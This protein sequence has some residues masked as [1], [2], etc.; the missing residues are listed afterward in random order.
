MYIIATMFFGADIKTQPQSNN[1]WV[2]DG[3]GFS[4]LDSSTDTWLPSANPIPM[5]QI[6]PNDAPFLF[7]FSD[8]DFSKDGKHLYSTMIGSN[9]MINLN[10][11]TRQTDS[12][13]PF[14]ALSEDALFLPLNVTTSKTTGKL[15]A[16]GIKASRVTLPSPEPSASSTPQ[17]SELAGAFESAKFNYGII[18]M[19]PVPTSFADE[20]EQADYLA[21]IQ[22]IYTDID[23]ADLSNAFGDSAEELNP[24]F[25]LLSILGTG[26]PSLSYDDQHLIMPYLNLQLQPFMGQQNL[27]L[28][29]G[30]YEYRMLNLQSRTVDRT[31][32]LSDPDMFLPYIMLFMSSFGLGNNR[33]GDYVGY[34]PSKSS[35]HS[36]IAN[37]PGPVVTV[38][39]E[40]RDPS[41]SPIV[42]TP[43]PFSPSPDSSTEPTGAPTGSGSA[44]SSS[45]PGGVV[46]EQGSV[47]DIISKANSFMGQVG[48]SIISGVKLIPAPAALGFPWLLLFLLFVLAARLVWQARRE[49]QANRRLR[50]LLTRRQQI[51]EDE[52]NFISLASH[53]LNTPITIIQ[54]AIDVLYTTKKI[55]QSTAKKLQDMTKRIADKA[56]LISSNLSGGRADTAG[57]IT[58]EDMPKSIVMRPAVIVAISLVVAL[59]IISNWLFIGAGTLQ[60]SAINIITQL[61]ALGILVQF[62]VSSQRYRQHSAQDLALVQAQLKQIERLEKTRDEFLHETVGE[63]NTDVETLRKYLSATGGLSNKQVKDGVARLQ[64]LLARL[65]LLSTIERSAKKLQKSTFSLGG[66]AGD[67]KTTYAKGLKAKGI[68]LELQGLEGFS[69]RQ[70]REMLDLVLTALVDNA[71]KFAPEKTGR[72]VVSAQRKGEEVLIRVSDN[73]PGIAEAKRDSLFKP[74]SRTQSALKF[75]YEGQGLSLYLAKLIL[76]KNDGEITLNER[77]L[78]GG[79]TF[80]VRLHDKS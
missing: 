24:I 47:A 5:G 1:V 59:V 31:L 54:G 27:L 71:I 23:R 62:V 40:R 3:L 74:F 77:G 26:Q 38:T 35:S 32:Q 50:E 9:S 34:L 17:P 70:S 52:T 78:Q 69:V 30:T 4:V 49:I 64:S 22:N 41:G 28:P 43:V 8:F 2:R 33:G 18:E 60:L 79:A 20:Q 51:N 61:V 14:M 12:A 6:V 76:G 63:L 11:Q 42:E 37:V 56:K 39:P 7:G 36:V 57:T 72:V 75:D 15:Y 45:G 58:P 29:V 13:L 53:Y 44:N 66:L 67:I 73:G 10:T 80:E 46:I 19:N 25:L 16:S 68:E 21:S 65:D 48:N 55:P